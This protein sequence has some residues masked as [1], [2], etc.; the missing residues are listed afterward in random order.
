MCSSRTQRRVAEPVS[1]CFYRGNSHPRRRFPSRRSTMQITPQEIADRAAASFNVLC[2]TYMTTGVSVDF[3]FRLHCAP[4]ARRSDSYTH[5][6]HRYPGRLTPYLPL[7]FLSVPQLARRTGVLVDPFAGCG[8]VLVEAPIHPVHPMNALGLEINPLAR[9]IAKTKTTA[10]SPRSVR[11][12]WGHF[13]K[14]YEADQTSVGL[15]NFP[16][17]HIWFSPQVE[18]NLGRIVRALEG[19]QDP[20]LFDF[21][22]TA[23]SSVVRRVALADPGVSVPVRLNPDRFTA[24]PQRLRVAADLTARSNADVYNLLREAVERNLARVQQWSDARATT[25]CTAEIAGNDA[26]TFALRSYMRGGGT[27]DAVRGQVE[28]ADLILTSPPYVN[29]QRYTRSLRL[30]LFTLGITSVATDE[31]AL[32][33]L[34]VG[35]ERVPATEWLIEGVPSTSPTADQTIAVIRSVDP[36]RAA[37]LARYVHDMKR[38]MDNSWASLKPG[39]HAVFVVGN[40]TV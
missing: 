21:F 14:R 8:T 15:S 7:F 32:D 31:A 24:E 10:V 12:G 23:V 6:L 27:A 29:A 20:D 19:V 37:I 9:V 35:T 22:L 4:W 26:R 28:N 13:R 40:N 39:G 30:E 17:K 2:E 11:A 3:D 18:K 34:Q 38:V 5:R 33:R 16:N 36:Y 1:I 25:M